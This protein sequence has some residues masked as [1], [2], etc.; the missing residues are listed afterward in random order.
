[1][2]EIATY[3]KEPHPNTLTIQ[4]GQSSG[5]VTVYA[6][7]DDD[8][9]DEILLLQVIPQ[10]TVFDPYSDMLG[11]GGKERLFMVVDSHEQGYALTAVPAKIYESGDFATISTLHF[12]PNHRQ[13]DDP[14]FVTLV[15]DHPAY[16][17][18]FPNGRS[19]TQLSTT[20]DSVTA[21]FQLASRR[22]IGGCN[23]DGDRTDDDVVV[24]AYVGGQEVAKTTVEVVDVHKLPEVT[25]TAMTESGTGPLT[26]VA[27]GSTYKVMVELNRNKP[28]GEVTNETI[29]VSLKSGEGSTALA[30][31]DFVISPSSRNIAGSP[32]TQI[33]TFTLQVLAGDGDIGDE[34]LVLDAM[35]KGRTSRYGTEEETGGT[36]SLDVVDVT[37][38]NVEPR[39]DAEVK[40]AVVTARN[41]AEGADDLWTFG[42][43]DL[44]IKLGDLFKL[45]AEGFTVSADATSADAKVVMAEADEGVVSVT[46]V[47]PGTAT[48]TVTATTAASAGGASAAQISADIASVEFEVEVDE[49]ALVLMLSGPEDMDM[50]NLVEGGDGAMVT[51]SANQKVASD[52]KVMIM[53]DRSM[54]DADDADFTIEPMELMISAGETEATATVKAVED[55]MAEDMEE[56]VLYAMAG[57]VQA[58]GEV[59]F[60]LWDAAVPALPIIAQFLL[61]A[62]LAVGGYRRYR[63]R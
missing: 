52:T 63:R 30:D 23:C 57:D 39:T 35:V 53:R 55:D 11:V 59:K 13:L 24:S 28:S 14:P 25:V 17:T 43:D 19:T 54:S 10:Q 20:S 56:L 48:V 1:M 40:L 58:T 33:G 36:L 45:P 44:A 4:A 38:L 15:S 51:V 34:M 47:G 27:E 37:T 22:R 46:A 61:S 5:S 60:Y 2:S 42:D 8:A 18:V 6:N 29:T 62:L 32:N 3:G 26:Q 12:T 16:A 21:E 49:L 31:A 50:M 41:A 9:E 7:T